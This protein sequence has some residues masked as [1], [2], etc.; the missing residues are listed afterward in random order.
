[1]STPTALSQ[2][3]VQESDSFEN[4]LDP[5]VQLTM[6]KDLKDFWGTEINNLADIGPNKPK[7]KI[8]L[9]PIKL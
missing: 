4:F 2:V 9:D 6:P 3:T 5:D 8:C 7:Y 1:M